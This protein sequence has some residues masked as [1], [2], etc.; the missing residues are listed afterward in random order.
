MKKYGRFGN[1]FAVNS[2][3]AHKL[4]GKGNNG[5]SIIDD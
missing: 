1:S 3:P 4:M 5:S 2:E